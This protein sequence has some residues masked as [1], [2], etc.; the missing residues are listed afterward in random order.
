MYKYF[1]LL[2]IVVFMGSC[3]QG[4]K[5]ER[6]QHATTS[7]SWDTE[8]LEEFRGQ[9]EEAL[10]RAA[11]FDMRFLEAS[12][13]IYERF[14]MESPELANKFN[15]LI[16]AKAAYNEAKMTY[17]LSVHEANDKLL[18]AIANSKTNEELKNGVR[19]IVDELRAS[20]DEYV[21]R[22]SEL[23]VIMKESGIESP[24]L[25]ELMIQNQNS[26]GAE[27]LNE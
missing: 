9:K 3:S 6:S 18:E 17:Q 16:S 21:G 8:M 20:N 7:S 26:N 15:D 22:A 24:V 1:Y 13:L 25:D 10:S 5:S 12:M 14:F 2:A 23:V 27:N 11:H 4:E 19:I